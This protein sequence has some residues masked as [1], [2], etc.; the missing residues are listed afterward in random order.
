LIHIGDFNERYDLNGN[1]LKT[2]DCPSPA[3]MHGEGFSV[4]WT[5]ISGNSKTVNEKQK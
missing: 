5:A 4:Y 2:Q 3:E 1:K